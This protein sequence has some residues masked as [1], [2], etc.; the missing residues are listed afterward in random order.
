ML[1]ARSRS[2]V[3][4]ARRSFATAASPS[5]A[6]SAILSKYPIGLNLYGF[7]IDNVQP[8]P[9]FSLVAV[10]LKHERSGAAHLHL[11]SPTDNNN[12]FL[13]AFKTNPPDATGVPHILEHTTLCGSYKYPVR[14]PFF[15]MTNRSL[16]NF[17]N[18]MTGHDFTFY[19]FATTNAKDF[20]N[21]M[22]VYLSSVFEP[23]LSYNDFIQEGWRLENEDI[24]DPESKLE[25]K[26]VVYNE[27]KGQNSNTS[28]YFYIKFL[29]SD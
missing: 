5:A 13:I 23:L 25:L 20:D 22:D 3:N 12:V 2:I 1:A 18:A 16:S 24:N 8:I 14:D 21:L 11:D 15:K 19:P 17:M 27:M 28:Y 6:T 4:A 29:E 9:E 26:G 7:V 10:H